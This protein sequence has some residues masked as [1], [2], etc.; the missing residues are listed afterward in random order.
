MEKILSKIIISL[1]FYNKWFLGVL[2]VENLWNFTC[3]PMNTEVSEAVKGQH[4]WCDVNDHIKI[5]FY[6]LHSQKG[7]LLAD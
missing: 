1:Q 4:C 7:K 3:G 2:I 6:F 5:Y